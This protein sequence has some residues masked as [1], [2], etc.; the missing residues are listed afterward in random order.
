MPDK[1]PPKNSEFR[2]ESFRFSSD[3]TDCRHA[4]Y[5][6][7]CPSC[8]ERDPEGNEVCAVCGEIYCPGCELAAAEKVMDPILRRWFAYD[9]APHEV[10]HYAENAAVD[11]SWALQNAGLLVPHNDALMS[12]PITPMD[13]EALA[14]MRHTHRERPSDTAVGYCDECGGH[15]PCDVATLLARLDVAEADLRSEIEDAN[16][17]VEL[18][19]MALA[20]RDAALASSPEGVVTLDGNQF[21]V[22]ATGETETLN[23]GSYGE[24]I[25]HWYPVQSPFYRLSP[26]PKE[27]HDV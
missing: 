13:G 8:D 11:L 16:E 15:W 10:G 27:N 26:L 21:R 22:E 2:F 23:L 24:Q 4:I 12:E 5:H 19:R 20:E 18:F 1:F 6:H 9:C 25:G 17:L 7:G 3:V 14:N